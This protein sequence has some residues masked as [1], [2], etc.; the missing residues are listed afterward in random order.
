MKDI[1]KQKNHFYMSYCGNK[2]NEIYNIYNLINFDNITTV[3]EPFCGSQAISYYIWQK[4]PDL[5]FILN[6]NNEYLKEM[7]EILKD[8]L[9][10]IEFE[11]VINEEFYDKIQDKEQY[12]KIVKEKNIYSW[13]IK[14]KF[15]NLRPGVFPCGSSRFKKINLSSIPIRDFYKNA[16]IEFSSL[17]GIFIYNQYKN[18]N[19]NLLILDPPYLNSCNDFYQ[20]TS[21]NIY[22]YL[23]DNDIINEQAKIFLILEDNWIIKLIFKKYIVYTYSKTYEISKKK[24]SHILISNQI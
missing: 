5:K 14:N 17:D 9:K 24:T 13:F 3:I 19:E 6:D 7:Y 1:T 2:R 23:N 11:K 21:L 12:L 8:D 18:N 16:N 20:D 15:Y 22:E 10:T 4:H